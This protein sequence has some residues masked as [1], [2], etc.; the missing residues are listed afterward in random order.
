[1]KLSP[2]P[3]R[4]SSSLSDLL[5]HNLNMYAL[6]ASAA[7]V[8]VSALAQPAEAKIVYT[9]TYQ[10]IGCNGAYELDLNHDGVVDFLIQESSHPWDGSCTSY[11]NG[12]ASLLAKEASGNA[13]EGT[14]HSASAL[15]AGVVIGPH[16]HFTSGG[17][18]GESMA[19]VFCSDWCG[20]YGKWKSVDNRYLGLRFK[21]KGKI[22]YGWARLSVHNHFIDIT[23]TLTGYAYETVPNKS[24]ITGKTKGPDVVTVQRGSLGALAAGASRRRTGSH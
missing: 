24:I 9:K 10:I 18:N 1:M 12:S 6:A 16:Q 19:R 11:A 15:K 3:L 23:A 7:G 4:T 8:S 22:H 13:V 2:R 21:I 17:H 14:K 20:T 5:H